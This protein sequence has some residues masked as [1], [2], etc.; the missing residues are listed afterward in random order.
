MTI[1]EDAMRVGHRVRARLKA[2]SPGGY[3][4]GP[5]WIH[6]DPGWEI[7]LYDSK[8]GEII[9]QVDHSYWTNLSIAIEEARLMVTAYRLS[10]FLGLSES[11]YK[12]FDFNLL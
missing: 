12:Y 1:Y 4:Y 6:M 5:N 9:Y 11:N 2:Y 10:G 3:W 7:E 8:T